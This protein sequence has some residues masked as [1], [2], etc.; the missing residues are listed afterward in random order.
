MSYD[1]SNKARSDLHDIWLYTLDKWSLEQADNY[2]NLLYEEIGHL[3]LNPILGIDRSR[4]R[5][6]YKSFQVKSHVIFYREHST[7]ADIEVVRI[8]HK[9][10]DMENRLRD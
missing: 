10:M 2:I 7:E 3:S 8:L 1:L 9:R 6:G 5:T 4:Y